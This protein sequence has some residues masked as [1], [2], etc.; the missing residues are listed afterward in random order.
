MTKHDYDAIIVGAR[1]AGA[2]TAML[3]ARKGHRVLLVDRARFP[4]EIPHGHFI[5]RDGPPRLARWGLLNRIVASGCPPVTSLT[6]DLGDFPLSVQNVELDGIAW[7]YGPRRGPF[8]QILIDA[9]T[10]A[11]A[12][13]RQGVAVDSVLMDEKRVVGVSVVGSTRIT[14]RLTIGAD[15][16]HSRVAQAVKAPT[17]ESVPT[18]MCWYF[19]YF[20]ALPTTSFEAYVVPRREVVFVHPTN[21]GL[22]AVLV[23]CP[24][25]EF[26]SVRMDL[27]ARFV[28]ALDLLPSLG[29]RV[30]S[31]QRVAVDPHCTDARDMR[32]PVVVDSREPARVTVGAACVRRLRKP[33]TEARG[34]QRPVDRR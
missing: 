26:A 21:D 27:E 10:T 14:S 30:R 32:A 3:L 17:Y 12:E 20:R 18:L 16:K 22:T 33:L 31:S 28:A 5:H 8:D 34:D 11:G 1:C 15:G 25:D 13:L 9:A 4:S 19:T 29:Q 23:G 6:F 2:A 24:I 7:G